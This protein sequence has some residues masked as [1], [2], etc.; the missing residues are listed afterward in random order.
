MPFYFR[1]PPIDVAA[2]LV[3]RTPGP[4]TPRADACLADRHAPPDTW[5]ARQLALIP[6]VTPPDR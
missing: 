2:L 3:Q 1:P 5:L 4:R 6:R